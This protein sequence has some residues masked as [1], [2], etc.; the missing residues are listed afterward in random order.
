MVDDDRA[1]AER[2]AEKVIHR[3]PQGVTGDVRV[4]DSRFGTM[5]FANSWIHQPIVDE[6]VVVSVRACVDRRLGAATS[7]DLSRSGLDAV[8]ER[9][10]AIAR[11]AP[12]D[13]RFPGF[14]DGSSGRGGAIAYSPTTAELDPERHCRAA[15]DAIE[16]A[17]REVPGARVSGAVN[18]GREVLAVANTAGLVRS[19]RRS[20]REVSV[21]VERPELDPSPSGWSEGAHWDASR[22]DAGQVGQEAAQRVARA[23]P[24]SVPPGTYRVLLCGPALAEAISFLG[25]LGFGGRAEDDQISCLLKRRGKRVAPESVTIVDDGRSSHTLPISIDYEGTAKR[26]VP[27]IAE[28]IAQPAVTDLVF[29]GHLKRRSTGNALPPESPFGDIGAIP[30]NMMMKPGDARWDELIESTRDGILVTRFHYVRVV[31]PSRGVI[32]GMTRDGTYRIAKGKVV[33]PVRNLRFTESVLTVLKG[34]EALGR[35]ERCYSSERGFSAVTCPAAV[36]KR[37]AF[38]SATIF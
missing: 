37:F 34:I 22:L 35:E 17:L 29:G 14:Q 12:Q 1:R 26:R 32:T 25:Y 2:L 5:R 27:L 33:A 4:E 9:A 30:T 18:Q 28:G 7:D 38:T 21:L 11:A 19:A 16:S 8:V 23:T 10:V 3:L 36:L 15:A 31:H 20:M 6:D 24:E 13:P